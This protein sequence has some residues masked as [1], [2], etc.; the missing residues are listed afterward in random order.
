MMRGEEEMEIPP[1]II[2]VPMRSVA[3]EVLALITYLRIPGSHKFES[4]PSSFS[5]PPLSKLQACGRAGACFYALCKLPGNHSTPES[6]SNGIAVL[7]PHLHNS[8][9]SSRT[10]PQT[11]PESRTSH[12]LSSKTALPLRPSLNLL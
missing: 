7:R 10:P 11:S 2:K 1:I 9:A 8:A 3:N 12:L 6:M 5:T 4:A